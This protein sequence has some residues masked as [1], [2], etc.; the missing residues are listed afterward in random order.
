M[1]RC[2]L[3][4]VLATSVMASG[5]GPCKPIEGLG[6]LLA[7]GTILLL[8]E[9]HGTEESPAFVLD[10]ACHAARSNL[11]VVIG[12]EL[13]PGEQERVDAFMDSEGTEADRRAMLAGS[14]WQASYQDGR[15]SHAMVELIDGL[16]KLRRDGRTA[17]V[18]LFDASGAKGGQQRERDMARNLAAA[19]ADASRSILIVLTGNM[20]SRVTKGTARDSEYEPMGYLLAQEVSVERLVALNV[21]HAGG[22]AWICAPDCGPSSLGGEHG[23]TGWRVEI[24]DQTRPSGHQGWYHVGTITASVPS[25]MSAS[26]V[27]LPPPA[28]AT[29][30]AV[31][32]SPEVAKP[33]PAVSGGETAPALTDAEV[34]I[35][36]EWQAYDFSSQTKTWRMSF[37]G[38]RFRARAGEDDWY[39]GRVELRDGERPAQIDFLIEDCRCSYKG[40]ASEGIYRWDGESLIL[41]APQPGAPRPTWFVETSGSMMRLFPVGQSASP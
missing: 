25:R 21:A 40:M 23:P 8:G 15:A 14:M 39:E 17:S 32:P 2:L 26:D 35:Q 36:G 31:S 11:P 12:L 3:P 37:D 18:V 10:A 29:V 38:R 33:A 16:R 41:A 19:A 9:I 27:V 28:S 6:P 1:L 34:K 13:R 4:L 5:P 20:H 22:S 30:E 24:D 7:P